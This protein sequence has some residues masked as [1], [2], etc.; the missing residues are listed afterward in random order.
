MEKI[1]AVQDF[2]DFVLVF[3]LDTEQ[4]FRYEFARETRDK[5]HKVLLYIIKKYAPRDSSV[6]RVLARPRPRAL[7]ELE[8]VRVPVLF[9]GGLPRG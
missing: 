2:Q 6:D 4:F 5:R 1:L 3:G 8:D 7:F 9:P